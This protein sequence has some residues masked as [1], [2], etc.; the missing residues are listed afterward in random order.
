M[1]ASQKLA[2][3]EDT[4]GSEGRGRKRRNLL[5]DAYR[6]EAGK[7]SLSEDP[8][9]ING[10]SFD[11]DAYYSKLLQVYGFM[12]IIRPHL[13]LARIFTLNS[14]TFFP[15]FFHSFILDLPLRHSPI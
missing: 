3:V 1:A 15:S 12:Y 9:D 10:P 8:S 7:H 2:S 5:L 13:T 4:V 6:Q 11:A 14:S